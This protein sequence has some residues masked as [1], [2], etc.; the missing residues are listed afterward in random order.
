MNIEEPT[1]IGFPPPAEPEAKEEG[2]QEAGE[3]IEKF[4]HGRFSNAGSPVFTV[5]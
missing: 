1:V 5:N 3:G 4:Y 2:N